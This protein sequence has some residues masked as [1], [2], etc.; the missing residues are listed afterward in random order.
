MVATVAFNPLI[1]TNAQGSF[2]AQSTGYIQGTALDQPAIRNSLAG[3]VLASTETLPMWGGVGIFELI[4]G[5]AGTPSGVLGGQVGRALL[6]T[7]AN[8]LSGFSV[9]DQ[10]HAMISSPQSPVPLAPSGAQVNF[11]RL[12]C[13]ARIAVAID[14]A[15]VNLDGLIVNSQVSWDFN[16]QRL[17][18]FEV[19]EGALAITS[20]TWAAGI[21]TVVTSGAHTYVVGDDVTISGAVPAAYNGDVTILTSADNTHFTY[22]MPVNPV[23]S[24]ASTPGTIN[25]GGGALN[26]RILD[27]QIGNSMTVVFDPVTGFATWKRD[28]STAIIEI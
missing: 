20:Q 18:P 27:V 2:N 24:P 8:Q 12:G 23:T 9:F 10:A 11:Y 7:G 13:G 6:L 14:P 28:G 4:P 22:A 26:V 21:V 16:L 15:L 5:A 17:V 19:A 1:T 25:A 3:G